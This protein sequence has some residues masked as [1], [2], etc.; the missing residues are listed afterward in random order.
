MPAT[1]A[2][3]AVVEA[4]L[5]RGIESGSEAA[6]LARRLEAT[7]LDI[8][9]EGMTSIRASVS[10]GRVGLLTGGA[11]AE[12]GLA[13]PADATITGSAA[14]LLRL[15][16]G[17][18][19]AAGQR[20]ARVRGDAEIANLFRRL[21]ARARPDW[22]E[23]LSRFVGDPAARRL[24][25]LAGSTVAWMRRTRRTALE[26]VAEYLQEESRDLVNGAELEEFLHGVDVL[27]E[28]ADRVEAR[29]ERIERRLKAP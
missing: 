13:R 17:G 16:S 27:R 25:R 24:S 26:N 20:S 28:T 7:A 1:P 6:D 10:G 19:A 18:S 12:A 15:A 5:N 4:S 14:A 3:I 23:E 9:I 29:I 8:E 21:I 2:W 11:A 22:E